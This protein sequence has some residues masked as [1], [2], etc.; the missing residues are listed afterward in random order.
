MMA[1]Y[2]RQNPGCGLNVLEQRNGYTLYGIGEILST[3][4]R[5]LAC[6]DALEDGRCGTVRLV[7]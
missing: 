7:R 4:P 5:W 3:D 6:R 2:G 1:N